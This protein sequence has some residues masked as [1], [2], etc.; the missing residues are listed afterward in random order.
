ML[1]G[2]VG[3]AA[4]SGAGGAVLIGTLLGLGG[5]ESLVQNSPSLSA[6]SL[7]LTH[8]HRCLRGLAGYR[9]HRRM[10]GLENVS[11]SPLKDEDGRELPQIPS[12]TATS[13]SR[14]FLANL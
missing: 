3:I 5:D 12:L 9:T 10:K 7:D 14:R 6:R 13:E 2:T 1:A 4:F 8:R 11:F